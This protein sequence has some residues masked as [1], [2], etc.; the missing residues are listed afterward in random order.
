MARILL[1]IDRLL[2]RRKQS[3]YWLAN[4]LG[5]GH[6]NLY[7][8]R[9]GQINAVNL[10]LLA[11]MCTLLDCQPGDLLVMADDRLDSKRK[12]KGTPHPRPTPKRVP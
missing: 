7:R 4:E 6:G 1:D 9:K 8:Y 3:A 5:M 12:A 10:D 11:R 2:K